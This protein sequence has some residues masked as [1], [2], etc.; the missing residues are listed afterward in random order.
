[1]ESSSNRQLGRQLSQKLISRPSLASHFISMS[2]FPTEEI[3][4]GPWQNTLNYTLETPLLH[5]ASNPGLDPEA[6][7]KKVKT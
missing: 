4:P 1:M 6:Q 2:R 7:S 3:E 5:S